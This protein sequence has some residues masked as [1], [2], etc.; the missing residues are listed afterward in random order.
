MKI[1]SHLIVSSVFSSGVYV[2][3]KSPVI[4]VSSFVA[5]IFL[6]LDHLIDYWRQYPGSLDVRHF[7]EVCDKYRIKVL[8]LFLH[9]YELLIVFAVVVYLTKSP[10][11]LGLS[12]GLAQHIFLDTIG[13]NLTE[14]SLSY[15]FIYRW[16]I[17]FDY[18]KVFDTEKAHGQDN[19]L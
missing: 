7:I 14:N 4:S 16:Y 9:S 11:L 15:F 8:T 13:N 19:N 1:P 17:G 2:I 6:D 3:T 5:G 10:L 18:T 12:L